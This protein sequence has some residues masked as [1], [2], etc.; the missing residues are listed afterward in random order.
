[1]VLYRINLI[2]LVEEIRAA[3]PG[4][5]VPFYMYHAEF[6]GLTQRSAQ[7]LK[8]LVKRWPDQG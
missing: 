4:I 3:D 1:M 7:M 2:L 6:N 5:L 8:L